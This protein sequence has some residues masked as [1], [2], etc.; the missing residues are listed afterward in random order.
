MDK[1]ISAT[2]H[3]YGRP[4][5]VRLFD[6]RKPRCRNVGQSRYESIA[7]RQ[8]EYYN[9]DSELILSDTTQAH[10]LL[11]GPEDY[12]Q[13]DGMLPVGP[14]WLLPKKKNSSGGMAT[15]EGFEVVDFPKGSSESLRANMSVIRD[16]SDRDA[17]LTKPAGASGTGRSTVAQSGVSKAID[18]QAGARK[19]AS[20]AS[21]LARSE[22]R[23]LA[24]ALMVLRDDPGALEAAREIEVVYP[25]D[26]NLFSAADLAAIT[27]D[28]QDLLKGSGDA[29][30]T[31]GLLITQLVR[32]ALP[33]F[34]A[35]TYERLQSEID[36]AIGANAEKDAACD[37]GGKDRAAACPV[38]R[39]SSRPPTDRSSLSAAWPQRG[40]RRC[41]EA[42]DRP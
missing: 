7:E 36:A 20:I 33:G 27:A 12:V 1:V 10:P 11:Q 19:L 22:G 13:A 34:D 29:P 8:R 37:A 6:R 3:R 39:R 4:P 32:S 28:I 31:E 38:A 14:T 15:Y 21:S 2:P 5:I 25:T 41:F 17:A 26:Y 9:R 30:E 35:E 40:G 24:Y 16:D 42:P 23:I 18:A